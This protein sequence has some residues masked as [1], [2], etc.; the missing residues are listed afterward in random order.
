M[1]TSVT[2]RN[3]SKPRYLQ[4]V[5]LRLNPLRALPPG[6]HPPGSHPPGSHPRGFLRDDCPQVSNLSILQE[7]C[8]HYTHTHTHTHTHTPTYKILTAFSFHSFPPSLFP[9]FH[10]SLLPHLVAEFRRRV[11][12]SDDLEATRL[13]LEIACLEETQRLEAIKLDQLKAQKSKVRVSS[14]HGTC[15]LARTNRTKYIYIYNII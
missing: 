9:S 6:F 10:P 4:R 7:F 1:M 5:M 3:K 14:C 2:C 11:N 15:T 8:A 13:G 12:E